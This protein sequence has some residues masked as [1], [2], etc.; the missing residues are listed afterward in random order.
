M[1]LSLSAAAC[2]ACL[3]GCTAHGPSFPTGAPDWPAPDA[4][5]YDFDWRLSGDRRVAP[6]QVFDDGQDTWLQFREGQALPAIFIL[7]GGRQRLADHERRGPYARIRGVWPVL[8]LRGGGLQ[9]R[10]EALGGQGTSAGVQA[11]G[12]IPGSGDTSQAVPAAVS[13]APVAR[14]GGR[15]AAHAG[16]GGLPAGAGP[17]SG[18]APETA[19]GPTGADGAGPSAAP[20]RFAAGPADRNMRQAL[21][22]WARQSGWTFESGHWS[23]DVDIPLAGSAVFESGFRQAVRDLLA[24]TELGDHPAQ[25]CFYSNRVL[26]VIPLAQHC[27]R[28]AA[29]GGAP[30]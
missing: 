20:A 25:P 4:A 10:A 14:A 22:R 5:Q 27:D 24:A 8:L 26:R 2:A 1:K 29:R 7:E 6:L 16:A 15:G 13:G 28:T 3:A 12:R 17:A 19:A 23:L 18:A 21:A 30:S 9:A 11:G